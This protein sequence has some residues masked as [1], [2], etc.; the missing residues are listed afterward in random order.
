MAQAFLG[1]LKTAVKPNRML[2]RCNWC[3][4]DAKTKLERHQ[5]TCIR[6]PVGLDGRAEFIRENK[7][8][9]RDNYT[10]FEANKA[11]PEGCY[12]SDKL[13]TASEVCKYVYTT[14]L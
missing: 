5:M 3:L 9:L 10:A 11:V 14:L 1:H 8:M 13:Y 2:Y 4:Q 12:S 7:K 6:C